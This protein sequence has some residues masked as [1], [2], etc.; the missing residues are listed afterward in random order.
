MIL[1]DIVDLNV[2]FPTA[3]GVV[4]ASNG[5]S[6]KIKQG[7]T[8][9][10]IGESGCGKTILA[11][12]IMRLLPGN[13]IVNGRILFNG[14]NLFCLS[15]KEMRK[16]RGRQIAMIFEQPQ[17]C[18]NPV[19]S[20]GNQI[21]EAVKIH[22]KCSI[23][24]ATEKAVELMAKVKIPAPQQKYR[25]YPHEYSGGMTQRAM[26]AMAMALKPAL[27]IADEPTTSLDA[28]IKSQIITL[29]KDLIA[30]FDTSLLLITHDLETAFMLC[31]HVSVMY[32]GFIVE[33]A[34]VKNILKIPK[35][36]YTKALISAVSDKAV[37]PISGMVP[38]LTR[39]PRGCPF[40]P[41]CE[42]RRKICRKVVP[43]MEKGVRCHLSVKM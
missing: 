12:G 8:H 11:L 13:A 5:V 40:H 35:H 24:A 25:Q 30:Q 38:E 26:I 3:A 39:L 23:K 37:S 22:E 15:E 29:L 6:L 18:F 7:E 16:I 1:L 10:L 28:T 20:V 36:P 4:Q 19:F 21:A 41:R 33:K 42:G 27:L 43:P 14:I 32:A 2:S 17:S 31:E 9:C 34:P